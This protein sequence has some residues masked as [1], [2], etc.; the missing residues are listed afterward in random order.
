MIEHLEASCREVSAAA[1][2]ATRLPQP[3]TLEMLGQACELLE[4]AC[5]A[6]E[7]PRLAAL[8]DDAL[9]A[10]ID[11][12]SALSDH[13]EA[14]G[15]DIAQALA[16]LE[17]CQTACGSLLAEGTGDRQLSVIACPAAHEAMPATNAAA[18]KALDASALQCLQRHVLGLA[19]DNDRQVKFK[20]C[21]FLLRLLE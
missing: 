4:L 5:E 12:L 6:V 13:L 16:C 14:G 2:L 8:G 1:A 11:L 17:V 10:A 9:R 20:R 19:N 7:T 18:T 15:S 21:I 3:K